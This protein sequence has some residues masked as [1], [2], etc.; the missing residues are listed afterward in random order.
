[1][2]NPKTITAV[3]LAAVLFIPLRANAQFV[4]DSTDFEIYRE[5]CRFLII[6]NESDTTIAMCPGEV[7]ITRDVIRFRPDEPILKKIDE[8]HVFKM[9]SLGV[10]VGNVC[11]VV[12]TE[13]ENMLEFVSC[14]KHCT[15]L[16]H[17]ATRL[18][19]RLEEAVQ[20]NLIAESGLESKE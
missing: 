5:P 4:N 20:R 11:D 6:S 14:N 16:S 9:T 2:T 17:D 1:M 3:L 10:F 7:V 15:I 18:K 19:E 13:Q 8:E 12:I